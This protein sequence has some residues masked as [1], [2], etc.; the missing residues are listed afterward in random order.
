[1][2]ADWVPATA[3]PGQPGES[4]L[5]E[6]RALLRLSLPIALTQL[7]YV[8][9]SLVETAAVGRVSVDDLAGA[10]IGRSVGFATIVL[11]MGVATGLEPLA[12]QALGAGDPARAWQGFV[13]SLR[14]TL[15]V[16]PVS[17]VAA[18]AVTLSLPVLGLEP[19]AVLRVR[20]Y[21]LGQAPGFAA[22][23][24]YISTRTFL[25]AHGKTTP[26]LI[27]TIV[28]NVINVPVTNLLVRGDDALRGVGLRPVGLPALGA[29]GGGIAFSVASFV[30]LAFVAVATLS[31]RT[32]APAP[33]V[34]LST[35]YRLGLPVGL[36]MLAEVGVFSVVALL[37]GALGPEVASAHNIALGLASFT[38]MGALGVS[39]ATAVRVGRAIGAGQSPRRAGFLGIALGGAGMTLGAVAFTAVPT[40]LVRAFTDD[41]RVVA[42]GVGLLHIAALFQIFDGV[43]AVASGALR[44]AGDMRF[45]FLANVA[46]HWLVGFPAA[47]T[48][49]FVLH[50]GAAGLWWGLTAGLVFVSAL[51][52]GRFAMVTRRPIA[53][54]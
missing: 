44:G 53:R 15:L 30:L 16:W 50:L 17:M 20:L 21:L 13:T 28:A 12:A 9:M 46:A 49:G 25:Q 51:L 3:P 42:I 18:F 33:R 43:Q 31:Y 2:S 36:Q 48:L 22:M 37:S 47:I 7:G 14:A 8:A 6:L 38:F 23:L 27:G 52:A 40:L 35:A 10:G 11:G 34:P 5:T 39:G 32:R 1:V 45:P 26:A 54:V 41:E 24:A 19:A 4:S 29:L